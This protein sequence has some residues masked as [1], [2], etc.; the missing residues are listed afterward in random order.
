MV[1][2]V[3][4][5]Y[6]PVLKWRKGEKLALRNLPDQLQESI[7]PLIELVNDE[8]DNPKDLPND[9]SKF[10]RRT[11]YLDVRY[12]PKNFARIALDNIV[13]YNQNKD[14]IPV[15]YPDSSQIIMEGIKNVVGI[16]NNGF[17]LR[18][19][20]NQDLDFSLLIKEVNLKLKYF[21]VAK[22]K[23]DLIV[24]F[25]YLEGKTQ[26]YKTVLEKIADTISFDDWRNVIVA[27]GSFPPNLE[28][29]RPNEDNLQKR[30]ELDLW[31]KNKMIRNREIVYSDYTVRNPDNI[32]K[33]FSRGSKS[34]RYTLEDD[35]QVFRG[36][37]ED[38]PFKYLVHAMNIRELY[39]DAY[40]ESYC[41]GD[42]AIT[43]KANQLKRCLDSGTNPE[44]YGG[45]SPGNSTG[46]V[47]WS[48]NHH[49]TVVLKDNLRI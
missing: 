27:A 1:E 8:G 44:T 46:W 36:T 37:Q 11:A 49:I 20:I 30:T 32:R 43:E 18:I 6:V 23:I 9:I 25:G 14:I 22:D 47:A 17:A 33:G 3:D 5:V 42:E 31:Q 28:G 21:A 26:T 19:I 13:S 24:D 4:P 29:F 45:F 39:S 38:K 2:E 12:R 34:V 40:S 41:W 16:Y 15:V 7:I 35:F 10:W 48:V